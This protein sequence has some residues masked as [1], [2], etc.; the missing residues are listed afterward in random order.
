VSEN[1]RNYTKALF[2]FDHVARTVT[3]DGW[4]AASPCE[5]WTARHV[6]GHV[7]SVTS[8]VRAAARRSVRDLP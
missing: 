4:D 2:G 6:A 3:P 8:L 7:I 1:L 5:G